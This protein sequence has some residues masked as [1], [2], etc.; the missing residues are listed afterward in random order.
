MFELINSVT[1]I[2]SEQGYTLERCEI[3]AMQA[4]L[5]F[6]NQART[7]K[8]SVFDPE[9]KVTGATALKDLASA[10]AAAG[11]AEEAAAVEAAAGEAAE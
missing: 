8:L 5:T 1:L 4:R 9:A 11:E 7:V 2:L 6:R 10:V 3:D